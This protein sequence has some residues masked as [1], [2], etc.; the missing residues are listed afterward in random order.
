MPM[1][2]YFTITENEFLIYRPVFNKLFIFIIKVYFNQRTFVFKPIFPLQNRPSVYNTCNVQSEMFKVV[3]VGF[4]HIH[5]Y[6]RIQS[7]NVHFSEFIFL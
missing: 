1:S 7:F 3:N 5:T 4:I 2:N 6:L